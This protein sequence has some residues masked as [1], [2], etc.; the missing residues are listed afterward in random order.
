M[1]IHFPRIT[2]LSDLFHI[3]LQPSEITEPNYSRLEL[4]AMFRGMQLVTAAS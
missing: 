2:I 4:L 3:T 1:I